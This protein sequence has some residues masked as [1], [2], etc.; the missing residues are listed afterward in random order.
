MQAVELLEIATAARYT[1]QAVPAWLGGDGWRSGY[2]YVGPENFAA[3][4]ATGEARRRQQAADRH[5]AEL[6][7][8]TKKPGRLDS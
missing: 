5:D 3:L 2:N 6:K 4:T 1:R 7:S 8:T